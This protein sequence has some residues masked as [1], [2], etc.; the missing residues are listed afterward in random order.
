MKV[1]KL[2]FKNAGRH[3]LRSILTM[4]G[5]AVAILA[6]GLIR[7]I[8]S[9]WYARVEASTQHRLVTRSV[10]WVVPLPLAYRDAIAGI[11]QV[12]SV[13][14]RHWLESYY[15]D[16]ENFFVK[17]PVDES[18]LEMYPEFI[19]P[20][21]QKAAYRK[22]RNACLVGRKLAERFGWK[23]GDA[24]R[25]TGTIF[26]GEWDFVLRGIY[27]GA[28]P[29]TDETIFFLHWQY[30]NERVRQESPDRAGTVGLFLV[31]IANEANPAA[32]SAAIDAIF[33]NSAVETK[34]ESER[35]FQQ[36]LVSMSGTIISAMHVISVVVVFIILLV[37]TNT[38]AMTA[39]ERMAE[40]A[41]LKTLGFR[42]VH[43]ISLIGGESLAIALAGFLTGLVL[44]IYACKGV[45]A[46]VTD[47][48]S[49]FFPVFEL[50]IGTIALA[51]MA[52]LLVGVSAA[53]F[54][55]WHAVRTR[56][57][58]GLQRIG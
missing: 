27:A 36:G 41:V 12:R 16:P 43:L 22:E 25:L 6:L 39:R 29:S 42:P 13:G 21:E 7:T 44:L 58:D 15:K 28:E 50:K 35:A 52:A 45:G 17:F 38:M 1:L 31:Q 2:I 8:I 19:V 23:L 47:N 4:L 10:S 56:I 37:L 33:K 34:T 49:A 24:I 20:A 53:I 26:P 5:L 32:V 18:Y 54:P 55:A 40:Y 30:F 11:P 48:L 14:I 51:F 46:F 57:A 3:K 9:A